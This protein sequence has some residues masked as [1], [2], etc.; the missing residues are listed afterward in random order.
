MSRSS[1]FITVFPIILIALI[2]EL[3][4]LWGWLSREGWIQYFLMFEVYI[5]LFITLLYIRSIIRLKNIWVNLITVLLIPIFYYLFSS[6]E[7][8][9]SALVNSLWYINL[10]ISTI[11]SAWLVVLIFGS[12]WSIKEISKQSFSRNRVIVFS[13]ILIASALITY[14]IKNSQLAEG[15]LAK[16]WEVDKLRTIW[17]MLEP[18]AVLAFSLIS[19]YLYLIKRTLA[20]LKQEYALIGILVTSLIFEYLINGFGLVAFRTVV[21]FLGLYCFINLLESQSRM[22][23]L[24][25][26]VFMILV[27]L[28]LFYYSG[29]PTFFTLTSFPQFLHTAL[30]ESIKIFIAAYIFIMGWSN[31]REYKGEFRLIMVLVTLVAYTYT[32]QSLGY[33][34]HFYDIVAI[35][36]MLKLTAL[37]LILLYGFYYFRPT[38][39]TSSEPHTP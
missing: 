12:S 2:M 30:I 22:N 14:F 5:L 29:S 26:S 7:S 20:E 28:H 31:A 27:A 35:T 24:L 16:I 13:L 38:V 19:I 39:S 33:S 37:Y 6:E 11:A 18:F 32:T 23:R 36:A 3:Y 25:V 1:I 21:Y 34:V 8:S 15:L 9:V 17:F 4:H 10:L